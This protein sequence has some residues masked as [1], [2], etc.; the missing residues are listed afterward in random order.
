MEVVTKQRHEK[1]EAAVRM[2][3]SVVVVMRRA[4]VH[5]VDSPGLLALVVSIVRYAADVICCSALLANRSQ[6]VVVRTPR[7]RR[8]EKS[9]AVTLWIGPMDRM[10]PQ[11]D[12]ERRGA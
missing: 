9:V 10:S 5:L 11:V 7:T 4:V 6:A 12:T 8:G 2:Q 1:R 3:K